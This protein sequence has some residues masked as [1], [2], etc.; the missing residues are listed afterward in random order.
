MRAGCPPPIGAPPTPAILR[1]LLAI[2]RDLLRGRGVNFGPR[3]LE[4]FPGEKFSEVV[5]LPGNVSGYA[6]VVDFLDLEG[7]FNVLLEHFL[8]YGR[9]RTK[10]KK[11][12]RNLQ[13]PRSILSFCLVLCWPKANKERE[14]TTADSSGQL[15]SQQAEQAQT[16]LRNSGPSN[17]LNCCQKLGQK[18]RPKTDINFDNTGSTLEA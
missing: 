2:L 3:Q 1:K 4:K 14:R 16:R 11:K 6:P 17:T 13:P 10:K 8:P 7:T 15:R 5:W 18:L 9:F 12:E